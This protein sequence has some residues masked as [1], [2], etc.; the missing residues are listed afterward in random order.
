MIREH[1]VASL[2]SEVNSRRPVLKQIMTHSGDMTLG[3]YANV[4]RVN[5][6]EPIQ[7]R[8]EVVDAVMIEADRTLGKVFGPDITSKLRRQLTEVPVILTGN[9]HG[10]NFVGTTHQGVHIFGMSVDSESV[11]PVLAGGTIRLDSNDRPMGILL[12]DR[13]RRINIFS[14]KHLR[15]M[16][17]AAP[18]ISPDMI[19]NAKKATRKQTG[20]NITQVE[21]ATIQ[22][23]LDDCY[24]LALHPDLR[25]YS[26]QSVIANRLLW[27]KTY[28]NE[29]RSQT[30]DLAYLE[31]ESVTKNLLLKDLKDPGSV[32]YQVLFDP[33]LRKSVMRNLDGAIGCWTSSPSEQVNSATERDNE[34]TAFFWGVGEKGNRI[35][36]SLEERDSVPYLV[37]KRGDGS[38]MEFEMN[39]H[40]IMDRLQKPSFSGERIIPSIFT[41][42]TDLAFAHGFKLD[43][44][45][46]Q[47]EYS[48]VMK[49]GL[50]EALRSTDRLE[51]AEKIDT[52][53]T[54]NYIT[55]LAFAMAKYG[56]GNAYRAGCLELVAKGG[57]NTADLEKMRNLT[58]RDA[59]LL[60]FLRVY[61]VAFSPEERNPAVSSLTETDIYNH[62]G[63]KIV[64]IQV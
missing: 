10:V 49:K 8:S 62:L 51:W 48:T 28:S 31:I 2:I 54:E 29:L 11:V 5:D 17:S 64:D 38:S 30:P 58:I 16:V 44:G 56:D 52:V 9:H 15:T 6:S 32:A 37:G 50:V 25:S 57:L 34:G 21:A 14:Q 20:N 24:P 3:Q 61:P 33:K 39:P 40:A 55:G 53:P 41:I 23:V 1:A 18:P 43:G 42:F 63:N 27:R 26:D 7:P 35:A 36:L 19:E 45:Y 13:V 47:I 4:M 59:N 46:R 22:Q 60:N 12:A